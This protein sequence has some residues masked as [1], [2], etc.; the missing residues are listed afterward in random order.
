[1]TFHRGD[2]VRR[3]ISEHRTPG[4]FAT[5]FALRSLLHTATYPANYGADK[6]WVD[7]LKPSPAGEELLTRMA[8]Q[9]I[10]DADV[11][12][13]LFGLFWFQEPLIDPVSTDLTLVRQLVEGEAQDGRF[14]WPMAQ[15]RLLYDRYLGLGLGDQDNLTPA[16]TAALLAGSPQGVYQVGSLVSGPLGILDAECVRLFP[17]WQVLGLWHCPMIDCRQLHPVSL[18]PPKIALVEAY[19]LLE[20]MAVELWNTE[21]RWRSVV[22]T[23]PLAA[24]DDWRAWSEMPLFLGECIVGDDRTRLV[25]RLLKGGRGSR[26]REF[27]SRKPGKSGSGE[28][29]QLAARL[30]SEEQL[31]L[32]LTLDDK[33]IK[34]A[35]DEA[36]WDGTIAVP[37]AEIREVDPSKRELCSLSSRSALELT[38]LGIRATRH[39]PVLLLRHL[40]LNAY[41]RHGERSD[42]DWRL[43]T[44]RGISTQDAL[45]EFLRTASPPVAIERLV[46]ASPRITA[47]VAESLETEVTA[48]GERAR[49]ILEWKLGFDSP[50][51]DPRLKTIRAVCQAFRETL[52]RVGIPDSDL[53]RHEI[54]GAGASAFVEFEGFLHE[55]ISYLAWLLTSDHP[56]VTRFI[57]RHSLAAE[58]V[59][60]V[61]GASL[62]SGRDVVEWSVDGNS[63][64]TCLRYAQQ[65]TKWM[66]SLPTQDRALLARP[67]GEVHSLP[68]DAVVAFPFNHTELWADANPESLGLVC[69]LLRGSLAS[70]ARGDVPGVRNGLEH[71]RDPARFPRVDRIVA[72]AEAMSEFVERADRERLFPK[73]YW[74]RGTRTDPFGQRSLDLVG[75]GGDIIT[76]HMPRTI[77]GSLTARGLSPTRPVLIA[78]GNLFGLPNAELL[79]E[80]RQESTYAHY[81]KLYPAGEEHAMVIAVESDDTSSGATESFI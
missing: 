57:Y 62:G 46:L 35:I 49:A 77:S 72:A 53:A 31:Q 29:D 1:M 71:Y 52:A 36:V 44:P 70:I 56:K 47:A 34:L 24:E 59:A 30:S 63:L 67:S 40:L 27:L 50:R 65:L 2:D 11:Y 66:E 81:W 38:S 19:R 58:C 25:A 39:S 16:Q 10:P 80:V 68:G 43:Q 76:I 73:L 17:P 74:L 37:A 45:M 55:T 64:G 42:L 41:D 75:Q 5:A 4:W 8:T 28:P 33:A 6:R 23:W 18:I 32:L 3:L 79:F 60:R 54:R 7:L 69:E 14:Y 21:S 12:M 20:R 26:I 61:L 13:A 48:P 9:A 22:S 15:G 78:P 51:E